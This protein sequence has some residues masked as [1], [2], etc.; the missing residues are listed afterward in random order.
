[1]VDY[2]KS[3]SAEGGILGSFSGWVTVEEPLDTRKIFLTFYPDEFEY[4][5]LQSIA[6]DSYSNI[7]RVQAVPP[8]GAIGQIMIRKMSLFNK[9][10]YVIEEIQNDHYAVWPEALKKIFGY[11]AVEQMLIGF[12]MKLERDYQGSARGYE[13]VMPSPGSM[14]NSIVPTTLHLWHIHNRE[15]GILRRMGGRT[16]RIEDRGITNHSSANIPRY[17]TRIS[18]ETLSD[19]MRE[20]LRFFRYSGQTG[21]RSESGTVGFNSGGDTR[22]SA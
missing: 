4:K 15:L 11:G 20:E 16:V 2:S 21:Y 5:R 14:A 6:Q 18:L 12:L 7:F 13:L 9:D 10:V 19:C 1:M 3:S 8:P 17:G 22:M